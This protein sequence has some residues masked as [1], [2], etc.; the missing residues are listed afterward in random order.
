MFPL[1]LKTTNL[2][3]SYAQSESTPNETIVRRGIFGHLPFQS[4]ILLHNH[5]MVKGIPIFK[6]KNPP[7]ES[8]ILG[9]HKRT[10]F[11]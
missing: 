5:S 6:E 8:C 4:L 1:N 11:P 7:C 2:T 10:I 3:Q 9:K